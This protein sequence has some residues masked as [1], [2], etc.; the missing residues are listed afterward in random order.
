[1]SVINQA[2]L[3]NNVPNE[4]IHMNKYDMSFDNVFTSEAGRNIPIFNRRVLPGEKWKLSASC[5]TRLAPLLSPV[6]GKMDIYL[7]AFYC[8]NRVLSDG[9][10]IYI[11]GTSDSGYNE[12]SYDSPILPDILRFFNDDNNQDLRNPIKLSRFYS[13]LDNEFDYGSERLDSDRTWFENGSLTDMLG[14]GSCVSHQQISDYYSGDDISSFDSLYIQ[15]FNYSLLPFKMYQAVWSEYYAD[16]NIHTYDDLDTI[17]FRWMCPI[18]TITY[19]DSAEAVFVESVSRVSGKTISNEVSA[20]VAFKNLFKQRWRCYAKDYFTSA[21]PE[22]QRGPDVLI[23]MIADIQI[24]NNLDGVQSTQFSKETAVGSGSDGNAFL[25]FDYPNTSMGVLYNLQYGRSGIQDSSQS[26]IDF[27][28]IGNINI[29]NANQLKAEI[30]QLS[31]TITD[32]RTAVALQEFYEA[33]ARYGN[34][35]KEFV[36]GHFGSMI[37]DD[38]LYRPIYLGGMKLPIQ[39]SEVTQTAPNNENTDGVGNLYGRGLS[40]TT[41]DG[42]LFERTFQDYGQI[43]VIYSIRPHSYYENFVKKEFCI[44]DRIDEY[45]RKLQGV[46]EESIFN[47]ELQGFLNTNPNVIERNDGTFGYQMRYSNY[48]FSNDEIHGNFKDSL[49]YMVFSRDVKDGAVLSPEFIEVRPEDIN[50]I[51]QY[52]GGDVDHF[53]NSVHFDCIREAPMDIYSIPRIN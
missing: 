45:W 10:E 1:M 49:S 25:G 6:F 51:F 38:Q 11:K 8:P 50:H 7:H 48:K 42:F 53:W 52:T 47:Y 37:P 27:N 5:F 30:S 19:N 46:G 26:I 41:D 14:V 39:I 44:K 22:P 32:L 4:V 28:S 35:Y 29:Y 43:M 3:F 36:Y 9:W 17:D 24:K 12:D 16:A 13:Y 15:P 2:E 23:P 31:A 40:A 33:S 20:E 21:L 18:N 34:R